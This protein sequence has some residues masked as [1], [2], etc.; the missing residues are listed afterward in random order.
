ML[1]CVLTVTTS[2]QGL[3]GV[4]IPFRVGRWDRSLA[5]GNK[6]QTPGLGAGGQSRDGC[7]EKDKVS[8]ERMAV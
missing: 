2:S 6:G 5:E 7:E 3:A 1:E 8:D 4:E